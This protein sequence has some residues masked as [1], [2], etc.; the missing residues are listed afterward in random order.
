MQMAFAVAQKTLER[1]EWDRVLDRLSEHA[2]TPQ[3]RLTIRGQTPDGPAG[4]A[5]FCPDAAQMRTRLAETREAL[6]VLAVAPP[7]LSGTAE[8]RGS[9]TRARKG[10][11]L[12][13]EALRRVG[14]TLAAL[15]ATARFVCARASVAPQLAETADGIVIHAVLR[16]EIEQALDESGEVRDEASPALGAARRDARKLSGEIQ[17]QVERML[18][19]SE[20]RAHLSDNWATLRN[21]RYVLPVKAD[22]RGS[23]PGIVHDASRSGTTLFIEPQA[24]VDLNNRHKRAEL[25]ATQEVRRVLGELSAAVAEAADEIRAGLDRLVQIDLAFAR[26]RY[27]QELDAVEPQVSD[28][29]RIALL[30]LRHPLIPREETVANDLRIGEGFH[31][32]VLSGPNAG[33]KTVAMKAVALAVLFTRCGLFVPAT[34]PARVDVFDALLAD[35]GDTQNLE[36]H[37]STFSGHMANLAE[38]TAQA[39]ARSLVVLDEI[40]TGTDP[41]EGAAIAQATLEALAE[42]GARTIATTHYGLLKEMAE[43]DSRFANASVEFDSESL[44]PT[45]RL[46]MGL[47]G[48]SS[49]AA[50]AIRMGVPRGIVDRAHALLSREDRRLDRILAELASSRAALEHEQNEAQRL[51]AE[52]YAARHE[53]SRKL[54]ALEKRRRH[55]YQQMRADLDRAFRDTHE[56]LARVVREL[57]SADTSQRAAKARE[58]LVELETRA[59]AETPPPEPEE[60]APQTIDWNRARPGDPVRVSGGRDATLLALPDKKGRVS[61]RVG[62]AKLTLPMER[63]GSAESAP[64][65]ARPRARTAPKDTVS[66]GTGRCD[67]RGARADEAVDRLEAALDAAAAEGRDR[68][69]V[70]HGLGTGVLRRVVREHLAATPYVTGFVDAE[71][72]EGGDGVTIALLSD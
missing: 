64:A 42:V 70:L 50:V 48:A 34:A 28:D 12:D 23:V 65:S 8:I 14:S 26:A 27:A 2:Q 36:E 9:L 35:I 54:E 43:I 56:E 29:A 72:G 6:A 5:L 63:V 10:G 69:E 30:Q 59:R 7:P 18:R 17:N 1:L 71:P 33:G 51:R 25:A 3:A 55:L 11:S 13:V 15:Q 46:R 31:V 40:G 37:L 22:A 62:S 57:Q 32:L 20:V 24:L 4:A 39:D 53:Y 44:A 49:A 68:L 21:D 58:A 38:V 60:P 16:A 67:L 66:G 61:V 45:Y 52:G 19:S 47:P 41:G